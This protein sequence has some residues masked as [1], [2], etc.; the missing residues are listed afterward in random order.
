MRKLSL[1]RAGSICLLSFTFVF[2]NLSE[3]KRERLA[4]AAISSNVLIE[5]VHPYALNSDDEAI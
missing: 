1:L 5:K 2:I 4:I 3:P